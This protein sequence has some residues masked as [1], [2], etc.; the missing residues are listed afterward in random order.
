MQP[1]FITFIQCTFGKDEWEHAAGSDAGVRE[2]VA[3]RNMVILR[4]SADTAKINLLDMNLKEVKIII[5]K[6]YICGR[7]RRVIVFSCR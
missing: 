1:K 5:Q 4:S 3:M 7:W 2:G 6:S